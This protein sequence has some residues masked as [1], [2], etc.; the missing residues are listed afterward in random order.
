MASKLEVVKSRKLG[1]VADLR[2]DLCKLR[3]LEAEI[4][5]LS[6]VQSRVRTELKNYRKRIEIKFDPV[7]VGSKLG[8]SKG[9]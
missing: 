7:G 9:I 5:A 6:R 3:Q 8:Y 2:R 4:V 1:S